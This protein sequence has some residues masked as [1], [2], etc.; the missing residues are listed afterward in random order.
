MYC[1]ILVLFLFLHLCF[2]QLVINVRNEGGEVLQET[3]TSNATDNTVTLEFQNSDGTLIT[4]FID[5]KKEVQILKALVLGEEERGQSQYQVMCFVSH[6]PFNDFIAPDAM[7]KLRQKNPGTI[8][9]AEENRG[10]VNKTL[11][12]LLYVPKGDE[13]SKHVTAMCNEALDST[14]TSYSDLETWS[15]SLGVPISKLMAAVKTYRKP[16]EEIRCSE[17]TNL[18][19]SCL[20]RLELHIPWYPCSLK[21]CKSSN[22]VSDNY[23]CGI[24]TCRRGYR[25]SYFVKYK[26]LCLWD[27]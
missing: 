11:G 15:E 18:W 24:K 12:I 9:T 20:C 6:I 23:K 16:Q 19:S 2:T 3:I 27:E 21:Y 13:I 14:Y 4:Q 1:L 7:A 8:R 10:I 25:F 17:V 5:F 22:F 26:Q